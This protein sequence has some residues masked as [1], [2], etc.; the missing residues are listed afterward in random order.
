VRPSFWKKRGEKI[1]K[2]ETD[3]DNE[4]R[5]KHQNRKLTKKEM[6][7]KSETKENNVR[8]MWKNVLGVLTEDSCLLLFLFFSLGRS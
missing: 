8:T 2:N 6:K 4:A 1:W 5:E 3:G 7:T